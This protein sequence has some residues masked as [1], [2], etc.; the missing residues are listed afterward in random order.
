M[1]RSYYIEEILFEVK[2]QPQEKIGE[3]NAK[4]IEMRR[5]KTYLLLTC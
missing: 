1:I 4:N 2:A 3:E 5:E